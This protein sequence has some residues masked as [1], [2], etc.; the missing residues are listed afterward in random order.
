VAEGYS[1][2]IILCQA[3][4]LKWTFNDGPLLPNVK[5]MDKYLIIEMVEFENQGFY[6]CSGIGSNEWILSEFQLL[7]LS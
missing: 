7:V 5:T 1:K 6:Q 4:Y 2:V 3:L